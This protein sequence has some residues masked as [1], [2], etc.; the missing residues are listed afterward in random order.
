[1]HI[2]LI[3]TI[4]IIGMLGYLSEGMLRKLQKGFDVEQLFAS[5]I[6]D[7]YKYLIVYSHV[8]EHAI[9]GSMFALK[10]RTKIFARGLRFCVQLDP[11]Y[12]IA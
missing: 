6:H 7:T 12:R 4:V 3:I 5:S 11:S 10:S 1:M 9:H 2:S 8:T